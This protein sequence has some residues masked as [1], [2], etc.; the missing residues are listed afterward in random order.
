MS[1]SPNEFGTRVRDLRNRKGIE[2]QQLAKA[3]KVTKLAVLNWENGRSFPGFWSIQELC[4]YFEVDAAWLIG[5]F[6][7]GHKEL[8]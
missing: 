4:R 5:S 2:Q 8:A 3:I 6:K 1:G 7:H